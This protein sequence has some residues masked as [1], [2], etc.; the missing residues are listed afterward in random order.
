[1]KK[2]A[3]LF[4]AETYQ[5]TKNLIMGDLPGCEYDITAMQ[6]RLT[7]IGFDVQVIRNAVKD[8]CFSAIKEATK[9][10]SVVT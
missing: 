3:V 10:Y 8:D 9:V 4:S 5:A 1:M 6:K 2:N 7:Q